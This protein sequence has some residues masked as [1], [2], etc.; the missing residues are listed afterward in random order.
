MYHELTNSMIAKRRILRIVIVALVIIFVA[1]CAFVYL[2]AEQ[3]MQEQ[4][5]SSIRTTIL[6]AAMQCCAIEGAYPLTLEYLEDN[7]GLH[8]NHNDYSIYYEAFASNM[9][10]SV[11]VVAK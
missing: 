8:I 10:P 6:D 2:K 9:P 7:Y 4:T 1:A 11:K 5:T 3:L